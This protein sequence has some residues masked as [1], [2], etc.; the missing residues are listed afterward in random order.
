M[1][2]VVDNRM[3]TIATTRDETMRTGDELA[4]LRILFMPKNSRTTYFHSLL[5]AA[6]RDHGWHINVVGPERHA[7]VW[8]DVAEKFVATPDFTQRQSWEDE[9]GV[10]EELDA[11][12][13]SCEQA[14]GTSASRIILAGEREIGRGFSRPI[15][16]WFETKMARMV[17]ADNT[18]PFRVLRR[19]FAF[20]RKTL[21]ANKPD[22]ILSG[23]WAD[24][25]CF[26]FYIVARQMGIRCAANRPSKIWSGRMYWSTEP[27]MLNH[28]A[29]TLAREKRAQAVVVS[30]RAREHIAA[31]RSKPE[32]LGYVRATWEKED[33]RGFFGYHV[34]LLRLLWA[35]ARHFLRRQSGPPPKPALRM[36]F[37]HYRRAWLR[38]RQA[39]FFRR[40][41][42]ATLRGTDY[43]FIALHKDPEQALNY[44][45]PYW[46]YQTCTVGLLSSCLPFGY[47]LLVRE[48]RANVG[49]R[50]TRFYKTMRSLPGIVLIDGYDDQFKYVRQAD[51]I[52][53]DN[54]STGWEG[55]LFGRRVITLADTF[56][57]GAGLDIHF[58]DPERLATKVVK[59]LEQ[60]PVKNPAVHDR[61]L[62][63][64]LDAEW[65]TTAPLDATDHGGM[66]A[67]LADICAGQNGRPLLDAQSFSDGFVQVPAK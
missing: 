10:C 62:G 66:L 13:S 49:R 11:F 20:A 15:Y 17:L 61:A 40:L 12:I 8:R 2:S 26:T 52:V 19:M 3:S 55:L 6:R 23:E 53:T 29:R 44:Q 5:E 25:L 38:W 14:S 27:M 60:P 56:Y 18:E 35:E 16:H 22:L 65:E 54:G 41:D 50:P 58:N 1:D 30:G 33:Q 24:P 36:A 4:D 7:S 57:D 45:A 67:L 21:Q 9:R 34:D 47:K 31:F 28:A 63:W 51:L 37:G 46:S 42:E 48:H 32:T 39:G 64:L 59:L 43:I